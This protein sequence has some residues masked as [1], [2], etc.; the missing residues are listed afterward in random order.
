MMILTRKGMP[1]SGRHALSVLLLL[2]GLLFSTAMSAQEKKVTVSLKDRPLSELIRSLER[3]TGKTFFYS[4]PSIDVTQSVSLDCKDVSMED[5]LT[6]ALKK[7][8]VSFS[9]S[10]NRVMLFPRV[11]GQAQSAGPIPVAGVVRDDLGSPV[12]SA[13]VYQKDNKQNGTI[14]DTDG[15]FA[16]NAPAGSMLVASS[17]G[18]L[19]AMMPAATRMDFVLYEDSE[20][21]D[22]VVVI[23]YGSVKKKDL[24]G[25]IAHVKTEQY[26]TQSYTNA[27]DMLSGQVAGFNANFG[28][29]AS[30]SSSMEIRGPASLSANN[31]PLVV[32]DG[33]IF[34]GSIN[35][36]NPS[37][38]ESVEVL[39]DASSAAVFGARAA[40]GVLM[41]NTK[42][43]GSSD[44]M[45]I[46]FSAKLGI[47]DF[48]HL[49]LPNNLTGFLQRREDYLTRV[50]GEK[51]KG[52]YAHPDRLPDGIDLQTWLN[53]D[54]SYDPDPV[55]TWMTRMNLTEIEQ[56]NYLAGK[57]YDW[58]D[59]CTR[60]GL[61][62]DYNV[63]LSNGSGRSKYYV[64]AGRTDN[65]GTYYG[66]DYEIFR[67]RLNVETKVTDFLTVGVNAQFSDKNNPGTQVSYGN[68]LVQS[69]LSSPYDADGNIKWYAT[70]DPGF[71]QNPLV[72]PMDRDK[73]SKTQSLFANLFAEVRLPLGFSYKVSWINRYNWAKSYY[74]D[75]TNS[76]AGDKVGGHGYRSNSSLYEWQLDNILS[77]RKTFGVHDF[78]ATFLYN[79]E[80][81][82]SWGDVADNT[83]FSP[84]EALGY[85]LL[86]IGSTPSI[87]TEDKYSTGNA[88]MA[89]LNYTLLNRYMLT[90]SIRR[91]GYSAFGIN[92]PYAVFP[93]GAFAWVLSDEPFF[94]SKWIN[95]LKFRVSYGLNG[96]RDIGIYS[97]LAQLGTTKYSTGLE[98][99]SGIY[100]STMAN[101]DLKWEKTAALNFGLDFA[102]ADS[103]VSGSLDVY[104]MTTTDL[105]LPRSL[106][107]IIGYDS[108]MSNLGQ[109]DNKGVELTVNSLNVNRPDF[110]WNS[111]F[112]FS[113]NRNKIVHLYGEMID[114]VDENGNVTGQREADDIENRWFIGQA[115]DRIWDYNFLGIYQL[116]EAEEAAR[117][118]KA[119]GDAK[120]EDVKEDGAITQEDKVFQ[121]Y[122]Q[123]RARLGLSNSLTLFKNWEI[124]C[125]IR[126]DLGHYRAN[127]YL[128]HTSSV[129]NRTNRLAI[130]YWTPE[131]PTNKYTRLL[132]VDTPAF[133]QYEP[134]GFVRLQDLTVAY[135]LPKT[136]LQ[137][138]H[139]DRARLYFNSRNLLTF[140]RWTGWDPESGNTAMPRIFTFGIDVTL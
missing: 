92:N 67:S 105:L 71:E 18:Y 4:T 86:D 125:F 56:A 38:I 57:E 87:S 20:Q 40:A 111:T 35:D 23:G 28:T 70:D 6:T 8:Q 116:A 93:S 31:T 80:K 73:L 62:Q 126:A 60:T 49:I 129:E 128:K 75:S 109:L 96:N 25:S 66:D 110:R 44:K 59:L 107:T 100:N 82:Q 119:P 74:Y 26:S 83:N 88:M 108:V 54:A 32:L 47:Q 89:R 39:K 46:N 90:A 79:A 77:W 136:L 3:Q 14:T 132:T 127:G 12:I 11:S 63:S 51:Q 122:T 84:S 133:T 53:Y 139:I 134:T 1:L 112:T 36:I 7:T 131:N 55:N 24:T 85:H 15:N 58:Y 72:T 102:V 37:D 48:T 118:G 34:N 22:D 17:I 27:L 120:L 64:S 97:A 101:S 9:I 69:P 41:I 43:G 42:N 10:G 76:P 94:R 2:S 124:S 21:L 137:R 13:Y 140:T 65:R 61:R 114:V 30:G 99:V 50:N 52:Y 138:V 113:A 103:R 68:I 91:D 19:E 104:K 117:F 123:P 98:Y 130:P 121:G 78:Y 45:S 106:P 95:T 135:N 115:I 33:V 5:A 81:N 29:S 16:L